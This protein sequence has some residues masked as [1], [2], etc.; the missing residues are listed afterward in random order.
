MSN[1]MQVFLERIQKAVPCEEYERLHPGDYGEDGYENAASH[2]AKV[3]LGVAARSPVAFG[4]ALDTFRKDPF[5]ESIESLMTP[6]EKDLLFKG[7]FGLSGFQWGWAVNAAA[8]LLEQPPVPNPAIW[9]IK[10]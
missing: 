5:T 2:A 4:E 8:A 3:L 10:V 6:E 1:D 7:R 9:A